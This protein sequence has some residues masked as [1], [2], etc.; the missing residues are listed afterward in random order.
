MIVSDKF[1]Q[2]HPPRLFERRN[3]ARQT[4]TRRQSIHTV[5][6]DLFSVFPFRVNPN[7]TS[8]GQDQGRRGCGD[9]RHFFHHRLIGY[10]KKRKEF[11]NRRICAHC[12]GRAAFDDH[13]RE[14]YH[15]FSY[16]FSE[17][18]RMFFQSFAQTKR[19]IFRARTRIVIIIELEI[20]YAVFFYG[21]GNNGKRVFVNFRI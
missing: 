13:I 16:P 8:F 20:F 21:F 6:D 14:T 12:A 18:Q 2:D 1:P 5:E 11:C 3:C 15:Q 4:G 17:R 9:I 7:K 19:S 10:R